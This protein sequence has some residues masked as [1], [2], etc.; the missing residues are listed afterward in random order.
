[1]VTVAEL[2]VPLYDPEPEPT[3]RSK[4]QPEAGVA[5]IE[6]DEPGS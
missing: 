1:M 2:D 5:L 3:Q 4:A 6:T